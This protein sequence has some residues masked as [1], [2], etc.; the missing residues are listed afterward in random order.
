M[1]CSSIRVWDAQKRV[2]LQTFRRESDRFWTLT[3]HPTQNLI[4]AG[5]DSGMIVFKLERERPPYAVLGNQVFYVRERYL[6]RNVVGTGADVP[7]L[8]LRSRRTVGPAGN[9]DLRTLLINPHT[10]DD[11]YVML[12]SGGSDMSYE[13]L[14]L[15]S[16]TE[17]ELI[18]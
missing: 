14:H 2:C 12:L 17:E 1:T 5:H 10:P 9:G 13:I 8:S 16:G 3:V 4:A 11:T 6:R 18:R 7:L 15:T